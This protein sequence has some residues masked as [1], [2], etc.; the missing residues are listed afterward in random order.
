MFKKL[1][2]LIFSFIIL[3]DGAYAIENKADG[4]YNFNNPYHMEISDKEDLIVSD[5]GNHQV[6]IINSNGEKIT[7]GS[8]KKGYRDG[9]IETAE[10]NEPKGIAVDSKGNIFVSDSGNNVIRKISLK[11]SRVYTFAG[12]GEK[13]FKNG[14]RKRA[15][16][17]KPIGIVIDSKG[18]ILVADAMN[19]LIRVID[20]DGKVSTYTGK[21][22]GQGSYKDGSLEEA[23]FNEPSDISIS[24]DGRI[25][26]A[27]S[28]NQMIRVIEN[29]EVK[30]YAGIFSNPSVIGNYGE[31]GFK[32]GKFFASKFNYP[33]GLDVVDKERVIVAD[34]W[35]GKIRLLDKGIVTTIAD[36]LEAPTD[37]IYHNKKLYIVCMWSNEIKIIEGSLD[38]NSIT[39]EGINE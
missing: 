18:R 5:S 7:I 38:E 22:G 11:E 2:L 36:N 13:G 21:N 8:G 29:N 35:N 27:D 4:Y 24:K 25:F 34:T 14:Q 10:F 31:S 9:K 1:M 37:V 26:I 17:D 20:E 19:N 23:R 6:V 32:N 15:S 33:K 28:G 30:K 3:L 39:M 16:F 12:S